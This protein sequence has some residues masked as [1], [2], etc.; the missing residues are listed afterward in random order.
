[1]PDGL[2]THDEAAYLECVKI[3]ED[4]LLEL[5]LV[6]EENRNNAL[7]EA[8]QSMANFKASFKALL[9]R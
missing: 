8:K 6:E 5:L 2:L 9:E 7:R 1:M 3:D 4:K